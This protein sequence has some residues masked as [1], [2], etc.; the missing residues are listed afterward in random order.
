MQWY[1][2]GTVAALLTTFSF[3]PR[4]TK[5]FRIKS[6]RDISLPAFVQLSSGVPLWAL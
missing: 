2:V 4:V 1:I 3:V 5:M 6:I